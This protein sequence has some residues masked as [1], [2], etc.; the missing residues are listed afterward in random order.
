MVHLPKI[1]QNILPDHPSGYIWWNW[2]PWSC[3]GHEKANSNQFCKAPRTPLK[4]QNALPDHPCGNIWSNLM[5]MSC[6]GHETVDSDRLEL[7]R[8]CA[9][10][11]AFLLK[12]SQIFYSSQIWI[13]LSQK[14]WLES[15]FC[16]FFAAL[17][18]QPRVGTTW[19]RATL[20]LAMQHMWG[21]SPQDS[22]FH[23][24]SE[25]NDVRLLADIAQFTFYILVW[26]L[27]LKRRWS[28]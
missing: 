3:F 12:L 8:S 4:C 1:G 5:P 26:L 2:M 23:N 6:L 19:M 15:F 22:D 17:M 24:V 16:T 27:K 25:R 7:I 18:N 14:I 10:K 9:S 13:D 21:R 11:V 20:P 28:T